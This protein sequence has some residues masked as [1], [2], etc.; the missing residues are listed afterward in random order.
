M[1]EPTTTHF[2]FILR[3]WRDAPGE[4]HGQ[5]I[6][7][8]SRRSHPFRTGQELQAKIEQ[9]TAAKTGGEPADAASRAIKPHFINGEK[10]EPS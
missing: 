7:A 8:L 3:C 1:D 6:E 4:L 5:L 10:N 9:L 2:S